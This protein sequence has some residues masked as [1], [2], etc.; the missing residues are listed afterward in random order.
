MFCGCWLLGFL[1]G[2]CFGIGSGRGGLKA[3]VFGG[4]DFR[5][6]RW[7]CVRM[8]LQVLFL[9]VGVSCIHFADCDGAWESLTQKKCG[10]DRV[11][12]A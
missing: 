12:V 1:F 6:G 2:M 7:G 3:M 11:C 8:S 5:R 10:C 4:F 9:V